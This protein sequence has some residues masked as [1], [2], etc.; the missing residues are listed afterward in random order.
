MKATAALVFSFLLLGIGS[1]EWAEAQKPPVLRVCKALNGTLIAKQK[2]SKKEIQVTSADLVGPA[3]PQGPQGPQGSPGSNGLNGSNGS[4]DPN[5]CAMRTTSRAVA[6]GF[7]EY[8]IALACF[9]G[10]FVVTHGGYSDSTNVDVT[11]IYLNFQPGDK[12]ATG[13][14]Y[15]MG[16]TIPGE[17][18]YTMY[19]DAMCCRP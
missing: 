1:P 5:K 18:P 9:P 16:A 7:V 6:G 12:V 13:I 15:Y 8:E 2:C 3:G 19:L 14:V 10:E 11:S 4:F 17:P